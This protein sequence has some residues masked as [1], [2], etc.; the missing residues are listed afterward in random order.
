VKD[1]AEDAIARLLRHRV[2]P[3][4]P[5]ASCLDAETVAAWF[6]GTLTAARQR[7][8]ESHAST[9]TRCQAVLATMAQTE[10]VAMPRRRGLSLLRWFAPALVAAT[11]VLVWINV[12][13]RSADVRTIPSDV[14]ST[15]QATAVPAPPLNA[16]QTS[17]MAASPV[18]SGKALEKSAGSAAV[19]EPAGK[20]P[21]A[22]RLQ[23]V[24]ALAAPSAA[25]ANGAAQ[26]PRMKDEP[27]DRLLQRDA[28][29]TL[30]TPLA[31][32][33][34]DGSLWRIAPD[35]TVGHSNDNGTTWREQ[36]LES[37][38]RLLAGSSPSLNVV[39]FAGADGIVVVTTDGVSWRWRSL[40]EHVDLTGISALDEKTATVTTR[41]GRRFVTHDAG[42][43]WVPATPQENLPASF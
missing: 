32:R 40:P 28:R 15:D 24:P 33:S 31:V 43:T 29:M 38:A 19:N 42:L 2:E 35:G 12:A 7:E 17:R 11:A 30:S 39:W 8:A 41:D 18:P 20:V 26:E 23:T 16:P 4:P 37:P 34:V 25:P 9:C 13:R 36:R 10:P 3:R 21:T 22:E 6:D 1:D 5:A 14:A 27:T